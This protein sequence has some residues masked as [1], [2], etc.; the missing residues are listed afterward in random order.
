MTCALGCKNP[1]GVALLDG[2]VH[3]SREYALCEYHHEAILSGSWHTV[4]LLSWEAFKDESDESILHDEREQ[5]GVCVP[6]TVEELT[7]VFLTG[8][9]PQTNSTVEKEGDQA[10]QHDESDSPDQVGVPEG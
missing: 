10:A 1:I 2:G 9:D 3:G 5:S 7:R 8:S 4:T 6:R